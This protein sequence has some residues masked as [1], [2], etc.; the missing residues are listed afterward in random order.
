M[1]NA[2]FNIDGTLSR[3]R[4]TLC[5]ACGAMEEC[6]ICWEHVSDWSP[7]YIWHCLLCRM[8]QS[9]FNNQCEPHRCEFCGWDEATEC[10]TL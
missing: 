3:K 10:R 2:V 9:G 1:I 8:P 6:D 7:F 5:K 4:K